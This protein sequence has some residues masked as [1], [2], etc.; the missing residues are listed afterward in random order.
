MIR[1]MTVERIDRTNSKNGS[2]LLSLPFNIESFSNFK[3]FKLPEYKK[4]LVLAEQYILAKSIDDMMYQDSDDISNF[5]ITLKNEAQSSLSMTQ[6]DIDQHVYGSYKSG[7]E[8][9]L[10]DFTVS[11]ALIEMFNDYNLYP[12]EDRILPKEFWKPFLNI[13]ASTYRK[14]QMTYPNAIYMYPELKDDI[15]VFHAKSG[16]CTYK[17]QVPDNSLNK[18]LNYLL[19]FNWDHTNWLGLLGTVQ[20]YCITPVSKLKSNRSMSHFLK[21]VVERTTTPMV[22]YSEVKF[23]LFNLL[24]DGVTSLEKTPYVD[25]IVHLLENLNYNE[26]VIHAFTNPEPTGRDI[27]HLSN[28]R[29]L[30]FLKNVVL[31]RATEAVEDTDEDEDDFTTDTTQEESTGDADFDFG[32]DDSFGED[33]DFM[34]DDLGGDMGDAPTDPFT[35]D[36]FVD[37]ISDSSAD[38][39]RRPKENEVNVPEDPYSLALRIVRSETFDDYLV[40]NATISLINSII[41]DPPST[42]SAEDLKFLRIWVTQW[43]NF[44]PI[45]TTKSLLSK[46]SVYLADASNH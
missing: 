19:H 9:L 10:R 30:N 26:E 12:E 17:K 6:R 2:K 32:T 4:L 3:N 14:A 41:I 7:V 23:Q 37:D 33:S 16:V 36:G 40:R 13:T 15:V 1:Y 28:V 25:S 42:L 5:L 46:L 20:A 29:E 44:Y 27:M 39:P 31:S 35:N 34:G 11:E 24:R 18:Q 43:I 38:K 45:E 8:A 21:A 22:N